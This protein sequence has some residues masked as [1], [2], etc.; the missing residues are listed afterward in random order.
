MRAAGTAGVSGAGAAGGSWA[1]IAEEEIVT[2]KKPQVR[3]AE[4][5]WDV[6]WNMAI[7]RS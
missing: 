3:W 7:Y 2:A 6:E 1:T 5:D 4:R